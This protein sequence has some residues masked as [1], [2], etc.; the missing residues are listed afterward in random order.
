M[1][2]TLNCITYYIKLIFLQID[3]SNDNSNKLSKNRK[4]LN[5]NKG[6]KRKKDSSINSSKESICPKSTLEI[7]TNTPNKTLKK[8]I[9]SSACNGNSI[10]DSSSS[11]DSSGSANCENNGAS[12]SG[13]INDK[14]KKKK[15]RTTFTGRQ[16][17]ELEKQFEIK[18]YLS[19]SERA[20][21]A[22]LLNVT[23]TQVSHHSFQL[24]FFF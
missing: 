21:M 7:A 4:D 12:D 5:I 18:K 8:I 17:F 23:E 16:I 6:V 14:S 10:G 11:G 9:N 22:K 3:L 1:F 2:K 24:F 19:S 20:E 13:I 15:A